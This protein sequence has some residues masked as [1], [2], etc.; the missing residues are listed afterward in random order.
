MDIRSVTEIPELGIAIALNYEV[1]P[2]GSD[3][4]NDDARFTRPPV[5]VRV[6]PGSPAEEAGLQ[7]NAVL[8]TING[9]IL[10]ANEAPGH[11]KPG[12]TIAQIAEALSHG[13][14]PVKVG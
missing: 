12:W 14:L 11:E 5:V 6:D 1:V 7:K 10:Y 3:P 4:A 8:K 13:D 9:Q 2:P